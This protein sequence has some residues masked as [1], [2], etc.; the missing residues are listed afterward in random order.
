MGYNI[1]FDISLDGHFIVSGSADGNVH[2]YNY[3][4]AKT[5]QK[6]NLGER[7][8]CLDIACHPVLNSIVAVSTWDGEISILK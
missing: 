3:H 6:I 5:V 2:V 4:N 8:V 1:G 7:T